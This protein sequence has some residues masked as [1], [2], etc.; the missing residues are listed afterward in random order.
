MPD[1]TVT[2]FVFALIDTTWSI[3]RS[4]SS[5][6]LLSAMLLKQWRVPSTLKCSCLRTKSC[7][8]ANDVALVSCWLLYS[9]LPDQLVSFSVGIQ[10]NKGETKRLA[11]TAEDSLRKVLLF[12]A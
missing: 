9:R 1:S 8:W 12:M 6:S 5:S 7:A 10:A 2:V 3:C 4:E 11:I